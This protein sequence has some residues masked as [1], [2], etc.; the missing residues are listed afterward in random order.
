MTVLWGDTG[1][2]VYGA[3]KQSTLNLPTPRENPNLGLTLPTAEPGT[4]QIS[5]TVQASDLVGFSGQGAKTVTNLPLVY[6]SG[7]IGAAATT[8]SY[9]ISING[10]S[11]YQSNTASLTAAYYYTI[12][13]CKYLSVNVGDVVTVSMWSSQADTSLVYTAFTTCA[14]RPLITK[15]GT[16]LSNVAYA[17]GTAFPTFSQNPT[18]TAVSSTQ[19]WVAVTNTAGTGTNVSNPNA[20]TFPAMTPDSSGPYYMGRCYYGDA[21]NSVNVSTHATNQ[22]YPVKN[23]MPATITFRE[24][25]R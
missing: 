9:R 22:F 2:V 13:F 5:Y 12:T 20:A 15:A 7:K 14:T 18:P 4:A 24:I 19:A 16:I 17:T 6:A 23:Y 1:R 8:I 11:Q 21:F 25:L 10:T 3:S